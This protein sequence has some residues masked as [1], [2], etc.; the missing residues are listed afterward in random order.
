MFLSRQQSLK[1]HSKEN[2]VFTM[3]LKH[4][5]HEGGRIKRKLRLKLLF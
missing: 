3:S 4:F 5:S 1:T 2:G